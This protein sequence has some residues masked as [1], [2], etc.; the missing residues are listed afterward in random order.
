MPCQAGA[1]LSLPKHLLCFPAQTL[2]QEVSSW[3]VVS[4]S[5]R[6]VGAHCKEQLEPSGGICH[7]RKHRSDSIRAMQSPAPSSHPRHTSLIPGKPKGCRVAGSCLSLATRLAAGP[8]ARHG[9]G[10]APHL[11]LF[12]LLGD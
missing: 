3:A 11:T 12:W 4:T 5:C 2:L 7:L 10:S 6:A 9:W 8:W 1:A